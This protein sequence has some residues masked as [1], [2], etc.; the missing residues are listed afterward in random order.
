MDH[1]ARF[2]LNV[3]YLRRPASQYRVQCLCVF[4]IPISLKYFLIRRLTK[5]T[6]RQLFVI[7]PA[8]QPLVRLTLCTR[9]V[10]KFATN[11]SSLSALPLLHAAAASHTLK[12]LVIGYII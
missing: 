1:P 2:G 4:L 12:W 7:R 11:K 8:P 5:N 10:F 6:N 9:E 3:C